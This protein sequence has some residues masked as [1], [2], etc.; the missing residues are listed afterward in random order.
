[1]RAGFPLYHMYICGPDDGV[2]MPEEQVQN[3]VLPFGGIESITEE[4]I[5]ENIRDYPYVMGKLK[6]C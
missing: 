4:E 3:D 5:L 6:D 2:C 1:M